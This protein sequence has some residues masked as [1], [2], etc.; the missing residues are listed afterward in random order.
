MALSWHGPVAGSDVVSAVPS[1]SG[2]LG[3]IGVEASGVKVS[4]MSVGKDRLC[5]VGGRVAVTKM[6]AAVFAVSC[7]TLTQE[8]TLRPISRNSIRIFFMKEIL[9]GDDYRV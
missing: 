1:G 9:L 2:V 3:V 4:E 5:F 7:D 6:G 8:A